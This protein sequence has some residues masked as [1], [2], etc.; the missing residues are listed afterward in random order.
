MRKLSN[1]K[2]AGL[3]GEPAEMLRYATL[4]APDGKV[5]N[6]LLPALTT[7][8]NAGRDPGPV[9]CKHGDADIQEGRCNGH[10]ELSP[11]RGG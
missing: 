2:A 6:L 9:E 7:K 5:E 4:K 10:S 1:G 3:S 11:R 8:L